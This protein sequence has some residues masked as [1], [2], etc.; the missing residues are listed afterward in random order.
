MRVRSKSSS[1]KKTGLPV[2][3]TKTWRMRAVKSPY[4]EYQVFYQTKRGKHKV[5]HF[6]VGV[7]PE[8]TTERLAR[9]RAIKFRKEYEREAITW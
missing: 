1:A 9:D 4:L 3:V 2:G 5:K 7:N 8:P 6:Y